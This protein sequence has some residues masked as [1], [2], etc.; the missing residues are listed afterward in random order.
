MLTLS[1]LLGDDAEIKEIYEKDPML[2]KWMDEKLFP[3]IAQCAQ[4]VRLQDDLAS[5]PA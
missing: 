5:K 4:I 3:V 2:A 1:I